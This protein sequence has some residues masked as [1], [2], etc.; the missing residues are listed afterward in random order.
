MEIIELITLKRLIVYAE[1]CTGCRHCELVCSF[2]HENVFSPELSRI[3]VIKDDTNGLDY[4]LTCR[5]CITCPPSQLCP[6]NAIIKT[7]ERISVKLQECISCGVCVK[8]C[9]YD[10][11]NLNKDNQPLVCDLCEGDPECV[12][13][14]PTQAIRYEENEF[15]KETPVEAFLRMK[16]AWGIE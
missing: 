7:G 8:V 5:N 6:T 9:S 13:R 15:F 2:E 3:I 16:E 14:C 11:I 10:A 12:K 1:E 4:P